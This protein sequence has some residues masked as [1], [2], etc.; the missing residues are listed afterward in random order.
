[1]WCFQGPEQRRSATVDLPDPEPPAIPS[2]S[3]GMGM[4]GGLSVFVSVV[5][6]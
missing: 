5:L 2:S 1:M 6:H 3:C 4:L